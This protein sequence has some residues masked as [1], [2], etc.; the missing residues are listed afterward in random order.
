MGNTQAAIFIWQ[1]VENGEA[2]TVLISAVPTKTSA[3]SGPGLV[4]G[5]TDAIPWMRL[6]RVAFAWAVLIGVLLAQYV[7][8]TDLRR[9]LE[10]FAVP[11]FP[12]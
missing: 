11:D 12:V 9:S 7:A 4:V 6:M 8:H 3:T 1:T 2:H 10:W 5:G